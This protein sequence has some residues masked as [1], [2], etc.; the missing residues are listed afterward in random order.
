MTVLRSYTVVIPAAIGDV[1]SPALDCLFLDGLL[2][3][4]NAPVDRY[5]SVSFPGDVN[6][7][8]LAQLSPGRTNN[9]LYRGMYSGP[10]P[11]R[12]MELDKRLW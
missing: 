12:E 5:P 1:E 10:F 8:P 11:V 2:S 9:V 4:H 7:Y 3:N 6:L